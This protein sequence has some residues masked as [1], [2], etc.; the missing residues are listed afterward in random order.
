MN[1]ESLFIAALERPTPA[2]RRAFLEEACGADAAL[3]QRL[4]HLLAAHDKAGGILEHSA[5]GPADTGGYVAAPTEAGEGSPAAGRVFAGRYNLLEG[6]GEG[7][8]G[9]VW[10]AQQ[11]EP[12]KRLVAVKLIKGGMDSRA[13]LARFEAERQAL[14]LMDHPNIAKVLDAGAA[15]EGRPYF[16]MELVKGVPLT[17]YCDEHRLTPRQRLELFIPICQAIQHAHQKGIIHRDIKPSNVLVATYDGKPVPKVID[18]GIAK[19]TGSQLTE[20]TLVTGFGAVVGTLEYMSPEQAEL[21]QLDIDTRSDIYSLGVLLYE[22]LTGT[23][24]LEKKRLKEA[25]MLELLRLIREEEPPRPSTRLSESKDALPSISAQRQ[26]EPAKLAKLVRGELDWIVMKALEKDR[27]RRYETANGL[28][29]D[30]E[31]YLHDEPVQA[32]PPSAW[33]RFRKFARRNRRGLMT[34]GVLGVMLLVAVGVVAASIGWVAR[35]RAARQVRLTGQVELILDEVDR[36]EQEQ[37]W[38]EALAAAERAEVALAGGEVDDAVR[39]RVRDVKRDLAFV[40]RLDRI[41]QDRANVQAGNLQH[42]RAARDYALAFREY[43]VDVE[44]LPAAEAVA[45]LQARP[46]LA[47]PLAAAL[48][49][50]VF[51]RADQGERAPSWEP[52]VAVARGLDPDPLRDQFRAVWARPVI[53]GTLAERA[54]RDDL[55]RLAEEIDVKG[56]S[57]ATLLVMALTLK[58]AHLPGPAL[59]ILRDGQFTHPADFWLNF[60]L[61]VELLKQK[62]Y[63]L[64][65]RYWSA[66]VS[67]RPDSALA[68]TNFGVALGNQK[69]VDE[70]IAYHRK[71]VDL[72]RKH[73]VPHVNLGFSLK[74]KGDLEGAFREYR[75]ALKIDPNLADVHFSLGTALAGTG[76]Q[77]GA[78]R[79]YRAALKIDPNHADAHVGL[80]VALRHRNDLEGA[81]REY[82]AALKIDANN[83]LAHLNLGTALIQKGDPE[84]AIREYRAG[85]KLDANNALTHVNLGIA[86]K[87]KG[88]LEGAIREYRAALKIDSNL[89]AAHHQ[90]GVALY[91]KWDLEG[92]IPEFHAALKIDPN[93]AEAHCNL[94]LALGQQGAL[95]QGLEKLRRG[96]E[97]GSKRPGWRFPSA[98]WV[99]ECE[100]LVELDG[101]LR[102]FLE[103]KATPASPTE[104]TDLAVLCR[105]KRLNRAAVR[106]SEEAFTAEPK[107]AEDMG[108]GYRYNA[109]GAAALAGCGQGRDADQLADKERVRLRR[110]ALD[111]LRADLEAWRRL[112]DTEPVPAGAAA[113]ATSALQH[114]LMDR[115]FA[116]V[117]GPVALAKLPEPERQPWQKLWNDVTETRIPDRAVVR[118]KEEG[119]KDEIAAARKTV[120]RYPLKPA[121]H[122]ALG[123]A[124][125]M[126]DR[127]GAIAA[128]RKAVE[129]GPEYA[130]AHHELAITLMYDGSKAELDDAAAAYSKVIE[131]EPGNNGAW[132]NRG[133]VYQKLG[134]WQEA[135]DDFSR[136]LQVAPKDGTAL[137]ARAEVHAAM[138]E[139]AKAIAD[140]EKAI[141][142][143][144]P[145]PG[146]IDKAM[147]YDG[148]AWLLA[149]CPDAR[150]RDPARAVVLARKAIE[151]ISP[152]SIRRF[153]TTL[154]L[155]YYRVGDPR[156]AIAALG[157]SRFPDGVDWLLLA[158]CH[159]KVG[160]ATEARKW[161]DRAVFWL[162]KNSKV[163]EQEPGR[164]EAA[165]LFRSEAEELLGRKK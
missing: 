156:S 38:P 89:A 22:L 45:R 96:H 85:L 36:L 137:R 107:L 122:V 120:A 80:G 78:I 81:F 24:P 104:R 7:G 91:E 98:V 115:A 134:Q 70:A 61:G 73:A 94:G 72:D 13:V 158:L 2:A 133:L 117:R 5:A 44:A 84:G 58:S 138:G 57:P 33:Y 34:A 154:G 87:A 90:L 124:L 74:E 51:A 41:R 76:D 112:L 151:L 99:R 88:D 12:V 69:K 31:R 43:G 132:Y 27:N 55:R 118:P 40:A 146:P 82:H 159:Q 139:W 28:A 145:W 6:I 83:A 8:M 18:F 129:L 95:R 30:I 79:E 37:K 157:Q 64:A 9:T 10:L 29:R 93:L 106:F 160:A 25:A 153:N 35:D 100:R 3:H 21:T 164:A 127:A 66:A 19:A 67:L 111:W 86:L 71:A 114:S 48:D 116:G 97:I 135:L 26:T 140:Y 54:L 102:G 123:L 92:A 128:F 125:R 47:V 39:Q 110:Q 155:A 161:Y 32:G 105:L 56:Q 147:P 1:E 68:H 119:P 136:I 150:F 59:R 11:T 141:A 126:R 50:W 63:S 103:G 49:D 149:T 53:Q 121:A 130:I 42:R 46:A 52:L 144:R 62:D 15:P 142:V 17:K 20:H 113:S 60:T 143:D 16:V 152:E 131:L 165:Q 101:K 148:L 23:T 4:L 109:A 163:L 108:A 162:E 75:A 65:E 77:E 14:A